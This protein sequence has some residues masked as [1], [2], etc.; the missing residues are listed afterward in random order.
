MHMVIQYTVYTL[1]ELLDR[2]AILFLN[3]E[4]NLNADSLLSLPSNMHVLGKE[5]QLSYSHPWDINR[6]QKKS[7]IYLVISNRTKMKQKRQHLC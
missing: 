6:L 1:M 3:T 4:T 2:L 5:A 7:K